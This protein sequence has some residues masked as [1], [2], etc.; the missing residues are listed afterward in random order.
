MSRNI[1]LLAIFNFFTD[2]NFYSAI[3]ILYFAKVTGSY[4]L[5]MSLFSVTMFSSALF[6]VPTGI[7]SDKIGRRKTVILGAVAAVGSVVCYAIGGNYAFLAVG[8][9]FEGISRAFYSGNNDA[10]L[11]DSLRDLKKTEFYDHYLGKVSAMF[12]AAL[13]IGTVVGGVIA[14]FSFAWVMWL[15]VIPQIIC[16]F[17]AFSITEPTKHKNKT[18]NIYA[19]LFN[20]IHH[21]MQNKKLRLLSI[22]QIIGFG[23][24]ESSFQFKSAFVAT[25]WPTWAIGISKAISF[26]GGG[27][28]FWFAGTLMK[29]F[30]GLNLMLF[31]TCINRVINILSLLF[32]TVASPVIMSSTSFLYGVTEVATNSMM[33]KEFTE[34]ER[35]TLASIISFGSNVAFGIFSIILGYLADLTTPAIAMLIGQIFYIPTIA[36]L[37]LLKKQK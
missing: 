2:F 24:G 18:T 1:K 17:V 4:T 3:L 25:L 35:A 28:S 33:Q 34:H 26:A 8:A 14:Y 15:S 16:L 19:H 7:L 10:L 23:V 21:I 37:I 5:A 29:K 27:V 12:Q 22:Y 36:S 30:G 6:E 32:P 13:T 9:L 31:D 11:H 20:S